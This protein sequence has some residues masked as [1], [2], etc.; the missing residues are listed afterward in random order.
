M[1]SFTDEQLSEIDNYTKSI[2]WYYDGEESLISILNEARDQVIKV[3]L[4]TIDFAKNFQLADLETFNL[5]H[6]MRKQKD[7]L[8]LMQLDPL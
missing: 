7:R 1:S 8:Y 6:E 2:N 5:M 3:V 4:P